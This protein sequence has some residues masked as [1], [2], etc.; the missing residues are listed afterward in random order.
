MD[1]R[2]KRELAARGLDEAAI[3]LVLDAA[4]AC[5]GAVAV[6]GVVACTRR[7]VEG[8]AGLTLLSIDDGGEILHV[9]EWARKG[10]DVAY[11]PA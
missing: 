8:A 2:F 9:L 1:E 5:G 10:G 7:R 3:G 4:A 11:L 6:L